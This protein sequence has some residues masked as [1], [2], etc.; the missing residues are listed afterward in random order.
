VTDTVTGAVKTY[1]NTQGHLASVA[2]VA[3]FQ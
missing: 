1:P 2:D 3:A